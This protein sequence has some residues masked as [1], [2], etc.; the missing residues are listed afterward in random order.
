MCIDKYSKIIG[1]EINEQISLLLVLLFYL[2][3]DPYVLTQ[4]MQFSVYLNE[5]YLQYTNGKII[6][7]IKTDTCKEYLSHGY[8]CRY[9]GGIIGLN[10]LAIKV[11][12][13]ITYK[14][15]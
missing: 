5:Y 10:S 8:V 11:N 15:V 6:S 12:L 1:K 13:A 7:F 2:I 9:R 14:L 3:S 4:R